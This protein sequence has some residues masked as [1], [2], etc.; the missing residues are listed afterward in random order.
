MSWLSNRYVEKVCRSIRAN[1]YFYERKKKLLLSTGKWFIDAR[2][3]VPYWYNETLILVLL[4]KDKIISD[5]TRTIFSFQNRIRIFQD[6]LS[7]NFSYLLCKRINTYPDIEIKY[8]KL[9]EYKEK[10]KDCLII[11][12]S[13]LM[14]RTSWSLLSH[15][16]LMW[17]KIT[18]KFPN[19]WL[20][21][22]MWKWN[23]WNYWRTLVW[24]WF[25]NPC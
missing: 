4:G 24:R 3:D 19:L 17:S 10:Y 18:I 15:S 9:E 8:Y 1:H 22:H 7:S 6:I 20:L 14:T 5:L 12:K 2:F 11:F 21:N 23:E 16:W 25:I 13:C